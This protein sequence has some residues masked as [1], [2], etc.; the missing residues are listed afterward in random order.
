[1]LNMHAYPV[2]SAFLLF[3]DEKHFI[4]NEFVKF[5]EIICFFH[6]VFKQIFKQNFHHHLTFSDLAGLL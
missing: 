1:M 5:P 2:E 3:S 6:P 4:Y